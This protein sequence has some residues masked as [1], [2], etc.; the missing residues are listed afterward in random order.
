M[1][2]CKAVA[3]DVIPRMVH[4]LR[5]S[6]QNPDNQ[7]AQLALLTAAQDMLQVHLHCQHT[8]TH[9]QECT[10]DVDGLRHRWV[11]RWAKSPIR[12]EQILLH[13]SHGQAVPVM[14][15]ACC[16]RAARFISSSAARVSSNAAM[17]D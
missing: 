10:V 2:Q 15:T 12:D 9:T 7:S 1:T 16:L 6:M 13:L 3:D 4:A 17:V 11:R 5:A 8:H 14:L